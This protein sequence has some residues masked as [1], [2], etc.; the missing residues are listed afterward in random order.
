MDNEAAG[1]VRRATLAEAADV[2]AMHA[3]TRSAWDSWPCS[4]PAMR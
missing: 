2:R 3:A 4:G 1:M